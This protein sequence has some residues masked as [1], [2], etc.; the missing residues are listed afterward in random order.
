MNV[1]CPPQLKY[2]QLEKE[3][4]LL[5]QT[6]PAGAR[7]P[8]ERHLA[9]MHRCNFLTVRKAL[10]TLVKEG[11]IIRRMGSGTFVAGSPGQP[12]RRNTPAKNRIGVLIYQ[13]S[14][15]Y[16]A[17]LL[18]ALALAAPIEESELR[19]CWIRDFSGEALR[20]AEQLAHE[21]CA[22]LILPWFPLSMGA[23]AK[24]FV[25]QCPLPVSLP[26]AVPGLE[27]N[28]FG[29]SGNF[30]SNLLASTEALCL[31]H[32]LLGRLHIAFVAPAIPENPLLQSHLSAYTSYISQNNL[33]NLATFTPSDR[34]SMDQLAGKLKPYRGSLGIIAYDDEHALRLTTAMHKISLKAPDDYG[35]IG[36]GNIE[37]S[38]YSDPPLST[39][40][41]DFPVISRY[42]LKNAL[43]L[44][45]DSSFQAN[46]I[47]PKPLLV[48]G[49]CGGWGKIDD[50]I[51]MQLPTLTLEEE[52]HF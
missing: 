23:E 22:A 48:R 36:H 7:L 21:G 31:Y 32:R 37:A 46:A 18:Q 5:L 45:Q 2:K 43:A 8:T 17:K 1:T 19:S 50:P 33:L 11:S 29:K 10:K 49:S 13:G 28:Y 24:T 39:I 16:A 40:G 6:L 52:P 47:A 41:Q 30:G 34:D 15:A 14:D 42:L 25:Q 9:A 35:I 3:V 12:V 51:R 44:S 4:R 38:T 26:M 20:Q 27:R